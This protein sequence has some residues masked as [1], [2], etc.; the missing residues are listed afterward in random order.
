MSDNV[1]DLAVARTQRRCRCQRFKSQLCLHRCLGELVDLARAGE[2]E[3]EPDGPDEPDESITEHL[4]DLAY[5]RW[6]EGH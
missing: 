2:D 3:P 5:R 1:V 6:R 4:D